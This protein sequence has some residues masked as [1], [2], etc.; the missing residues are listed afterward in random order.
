MQLD[1]RGGREADG[2]VLRQH[3]LE[4]NLMAEDVE[5]MFLPSPSH[6]VIARMLERLSY[7]TSAVM[8]PVRLKLGRDSVATDLIDADVVV[9]GVGVERYG[10]IEG[11]ELHCH[12]AAVPGGHGV[13]ALVGEPD[14][15]GVAP[16]NPSAGR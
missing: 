12:E 13:G 3:D 15:L 2:D 7:L 9:G 8:F 6:S 11:V 14:V 16:P 4:V 1:G 5:D 10:V